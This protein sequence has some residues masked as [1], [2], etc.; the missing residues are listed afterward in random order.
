MTD[1]PTRL[2]THDVPHVPHVPHIG[3]S[4]NLLTPQGNSLN[5]VQITCAMALLQAGVDL[6]T[7]ALWLGHEGIETVQIYLHADLKLKEQAIAR[8][9]PPAAGT[10]R[11]RASDPLLAFLAT[12]G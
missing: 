8:T 2:T 7:I 6:S 12:L 4:Q 11:F 5:R 10:H 1:N 9:A 3:Q